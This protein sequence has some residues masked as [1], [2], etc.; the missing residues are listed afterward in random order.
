M[1]MELDL[2]SLDISNISDIEEDLSDVAVLNLHGNSLSTLYGI[3]ETS[4]LVE[5]NLSSNSFVSCDLPELVYLPSLKVLDL[6]GNRIAS[7]QGLPFLPS[8]TSFAVAFN[9]IY[10]L[11]GVYD[12]PNLEVLD[13]RG[14]LI[15]SAKDCAHIQPLGMLRDLW[16]SNTDGRYSNPVCSKAAEILK[17]FDDTRYFGCIDGS[18]RQR[19]ALDAVPSISFTPKFDMVAKKF[20]S[21]GGGDK[22]LNPSAVENT[23]SGSS[24]SHDE[25][26]SD[27]GS[28][29]Q[30]LESKNDMQIPAQHC[31]SV[32]SAM[33][34]RWLQGRF[35]IWC[36]AA[37]R[38]SGLVTERAVSSS[39]ASQQMLALESVIADEKQKIRILE[40]VICE[41]K[42]KADTEEDR[43]LTEL[44]AARRVAEAERQRSEQLRVQL[45]KHVAISNTQNAELQKSRQMCANLE[46]EG[47]KAA[48]AMKVYD[49]SIIELQAELSRANQIRLEAEEMQRHLHNEAEQL[50][51]C[52]SSITLELEESR[53]QCEGL[54][55]Q[56]HRVEMDVVVMQ[57]D[58][59]SLQS[60]L[61]VAGQELVETG[62]LLS[63]REKD[64]QDLETCLAEEAVTRGNL[65]KTIDDMQSVLTQLRDELAVSKS[66]AEE[67]KVS[68]EDLCSIVVDLKST[69]KKNHARCKHL[70]SQRDKTRE[71]LEALVAQQHSDTSHFTDEKRTLKQQYNIAMESLQKEFKAVS[72]KKET[73]E[74]SIDQL[75]YDI[76]TLNESS[77][78][79][80]QVLRRAEQRA[81]ELQHAL[82]VKD[83]MLDD[84]S[85][86]ISEL[87]D[88]LGAET[89]EASQ[90]VCLSF[91]LLT[92]NSRYQSA[93]DL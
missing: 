48:E 59:S 75:H 64:V 62:K 72:A 49:A 12:F 33:H 9:A 93:S 85:D 76:K 15:A 11:D 47:K 6:S 7:L 54:K 89:I 13:C 43:F 23:R 45:L 38:L 28:F 34:K 19:W 10:S 3:M 31:I 18:D 50:R 8:V 4:K 80:K 65:T 84:Q 58:Q 60:Q 5:L 51:S 57:E 79:D 61:K 87:R 71:Q 41:L 21:H 86:L 90:R 46:A 2:I 69:L 63:Q 74:R 52:V 14:N 29:S 88:R 70:E 36:R 17:I 32:L 39:V 77:A 82:K 42:T 25:D 83:K 66:F 30:V 73:L 56:L 27:T 44:E 92:A 1:M 35:N 26:T 20:L 37:C 78:K 55:Q 68:I 24:Y 22:S 67:Q 53:V 40:E 16:L 91:Y 81:D